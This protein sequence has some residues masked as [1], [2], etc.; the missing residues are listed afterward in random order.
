METQNPPMQSDSLVD[1]QADLMRRMTALLLDM[2][3]PCFVTREVREQQDM[4]EQMRAMED[5]SW[6]LTRRINRTNP[7][8]NN[9]G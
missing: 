5:Y 2:R 9:Q 1:E 8:T 6:F 4:R 3:R 7:T